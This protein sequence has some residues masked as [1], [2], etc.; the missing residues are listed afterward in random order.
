M[1]DGDQYRTGPDE[2]ESC[3]VTPPPGNAAIDTAMAPGAQA[4]VAQGCTC[5]VLANAAFRADAPGETPFIDPRCP[6]HALR[7]R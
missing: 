4:A 3:T 6:L 7:D 2:V 1:S 5:S